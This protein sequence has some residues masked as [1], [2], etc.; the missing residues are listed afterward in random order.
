MFDD[1]KRSVLEHIKMLKGYA[2]SIYGASK[3]ELDEA[4]DLNES[5][6][7]KLITVDGPTRPPIADREPWPPND[8]GPNDGSPLNES[9]HI[10]IT[11]GLDSVIPVEVW[12]TMSEQEREE[13]RKAR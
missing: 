13:A 3:P 11:E 5:Q 1:N 7:P 10:K 12:E 4:H 9:H 2:L 8:D 6:G